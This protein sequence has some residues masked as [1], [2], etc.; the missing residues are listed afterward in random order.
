MPAL[1]IRPIAT[2][3]SSTETPS[4]FATG[5]AYLKASP[6]PVT[7]VAELLA[8]CTRASTTRAAS[9]AC[10]PKPLIVAPT[11][12]PM[13]SKLVPVASAPRTIAGRALSTWETLKPARTRLVAISATCCVVPAASMPTR[14]ITA[15]SRS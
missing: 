13:V 14:S 11:T 10:R 15:A 8:P 4:T 6:I 12:S 1:V 9:D 7:E 2:P 3:R 5:A